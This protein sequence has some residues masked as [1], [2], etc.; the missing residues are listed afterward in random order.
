MAAPRHVV[1]LLASR[2]ESGRCMNNVNNGTEP[3]CDF[4]G[5]LYA[6]Y[7]DARTKT[8][9]KDVTGSR[10]HS[11]NGLVSRSYRSKL[12]TLVTRETGSCNLTHYKEN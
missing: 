10:C 1:D 4:D 3:W 12:G 6:I 11:R 5:G 9:S 2:Y 7:R 8:C